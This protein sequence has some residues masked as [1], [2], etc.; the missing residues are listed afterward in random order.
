VAA[1]EEGVVA[2]AS[3]LI[4]A[5]TSSSVKVMWSVHSHDPTQTK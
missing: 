3:K 4:V 2:G 5:A 1:V